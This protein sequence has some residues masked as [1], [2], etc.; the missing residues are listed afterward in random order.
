M[1]RPH[2]A[3]PSARQVYAANGAPAVAGTF[4]WALSATAKQPLKCRDRTESFQSG[5]LWGPTV[6][7]AEPKMS[8]QHRFFMLSF[9]MIWQGQSLSSPSPRVRQR[10]LADQVLL[11]LF[12][13]A[14]W[15]A[16]LRRFT[17]R[18]T[19]MFGAFLSEVLC[20]LG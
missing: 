14:L 3:S 20:A 13:F 10:A 18:L 1:P 15:R 4:A 12:R 8:V 2:R 19:S 5:S 6:N 16:M 9:E 17:A 11:P 7:T